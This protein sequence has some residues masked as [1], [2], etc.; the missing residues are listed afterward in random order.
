MAAFDRPQAL[1]GG[2]MGKP[3]IMGRKTWQR[4]RHGR[5]PG[6]STSWSRATGVFAPKAPRS[7]ASLDDALALAKARARCMAGADEICVIGGGEIYRA[8]D[9]ACRPALRHACA[10]EVEGDTR[11]PPIDPDIWRDCQHRGLSGGRKGQPCDALCGLR[12]AHRQCIEGS[13]SR[14]QRRRFKSPAARAARVESAAAHP[15]KENTGARAGL[16][17]RAWV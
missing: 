10:G 15:Y 3:I 17:R 11:F 16:D 6:G 5:C 9:A 13:H 12:A 14:D 7:A 1:Q 4:A 8:G 2:T